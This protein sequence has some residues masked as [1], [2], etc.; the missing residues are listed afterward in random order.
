MRDERTTTINLKKIL[1]SITNC[2]VY[3]SLYNVYRPIICL[4]L[5]DFFSFIFIKFI[6]VKYVA[7][8]MSPRPGSDF[9][10]YVSKS[11]QIYSSN[12]FFFHAIV[13]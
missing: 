10:M 4:S 9:S 7:I 11:S 5:L 6:F 12:S 8:I 1:Y 2:P 3:L 13:N